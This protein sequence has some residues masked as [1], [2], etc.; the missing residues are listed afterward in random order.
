MLDAASHTCY[1]NYDKCFCYGHG[2][3]KRMM[4][5]EMSLDTWE[6]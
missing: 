6:L 4:T 1:C 3:N 5:T 2:T